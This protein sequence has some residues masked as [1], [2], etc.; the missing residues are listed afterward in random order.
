MKHPELAEFRKSK[1]A[2]IGIYPGWACEECMLQRFGKD[3][4]RSGICYDSRNG[5]RRNS[6]DFAEWFFA[7]EGLVAAHAECI[8]SSNFFA[9]K[10]V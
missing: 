6:R 4:E 3:T 10:R 7:E 1:K 5:R 2:F 9:G 8:E